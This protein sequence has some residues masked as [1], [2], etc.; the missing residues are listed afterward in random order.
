MRTILLDT[1]PL[2]EVVHQNKNTRAPIEAWMQQMVVKGVTIRIPGIADYELRRELIRSRFADSVHALDQ[3]IQV[4]GYL[5]I[6]QETTNCACELWAQARNLSQ[7][8]A[9]DDSLDGDMIL[10]AHAIH[11]CQGDCIIAT[12]N[13]RHISRFVTAK[14][15][16]EITITDLS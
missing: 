13:P 14:K 6:S 16:T 11:D 7:A 5:P 12:T 9:S 3:L 1:G 10:C 4:L 2:G 15:W 8:T